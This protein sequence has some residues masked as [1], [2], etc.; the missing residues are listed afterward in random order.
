MEA[1]KTFFFLNQGFTEQ[2]VEVAVYPGGNPL[3]VPII[4]GQGG[5]VDGYKNKYQIIASKLVEK[6]GANIFVVENQ[7]PLEAMAH[8]FIQSTMEFIEE[9]MSCFWFEKWES[10]AMGSSAWGL[11]LANCLDAYPQI[12]RLLLINPVLS[13]DFEQNIKNLINFQGQLTIIHG[14]E[15]GE[16]DLH[17]VLKEKLV[18]S[19]KN[20]LLLEGVDHLFSNPWGF[21]GYLE[22]PEKYLFSGKTSFNKQK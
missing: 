16:A 8:P 15:D 17:E 21:E 18:W 4:V 19:K 11:F 7:L 3:A 5:S 1:E 12:S 14:S 2:M 22:L 10:F 13:I 9:T 20:I 6:Y